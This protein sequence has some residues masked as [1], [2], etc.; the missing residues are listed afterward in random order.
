[1]SDLFQILYVST[2]ARDL[3]ELELNAILASSRRNNAFNSI[4]GMLL[5]LDQNFIQV[6]EGP[7]E[8]VERTFRT[9]QNDL[10]HRGVAILLRRSIVA[11]DFKNWS[12][13]FE[14]LDH[15]EGKV[16]E[17][18]FQVSAANIYERRSDTHGAVVMAFMRT[19]YRI[20][21]RSHLDGMA[22]S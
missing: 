7:T 3:P 16:L 21:T 11:R 13:G 20:A 17:G 18:A 8:A 5:F 12:M 10:R 4:S 2:A 6:L 19:F 9:I 14:R 1:M 15:L 22:P